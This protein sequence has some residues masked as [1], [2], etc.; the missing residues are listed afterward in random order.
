MAKIS[1]IN[2]SKL[3]KKIGKIR[4]TF[5]AAKIF[6]KFDILSPSRGGFFG[7]VTKY[8]LCPSGACPAGF[9][10]EVCVGKKE[11]T[12][13]NSFFRIYTAYSLK[14]TFYFPLACV[15]IK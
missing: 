9:R 13:R 10:P 15:I 8:F 3:C 11:E 12:S 2:W 5:A 6:R 14:I 4:K 1:T 7:K